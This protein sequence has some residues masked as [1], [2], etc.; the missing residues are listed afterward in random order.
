M[1][2]HSEILNRMKKRFS[3]FT[4][5]EIP[6]KSA[7]F[8]LKMNLP[9]LIGR[10]DAAAEAMNKIMQ[11]DLFSFKPAERIKIYHTEVTLLSSI[12]KDTYTILSMLTSPDTSSRER[13]MLKFWT[14][15]FDS[16]FCLETLAAADERLSQD[17]ETATDGF[18]SSSKL[19]K[20][21][22]F[23]GLNETEIRLSNRLRELFDAGAARLTRYREY[24]VKSFSKAYSERYFKAYNEYLE[25]YS[26]SVPHQ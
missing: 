6:S 11:L 15:L 21:P 23:S 1:D 12:K 17:P 3:I 14:L 18:I 25:L 5:Q 22:A 7:D 26:S 20:I 4:T 19:S 2:L 10:R 24:A 8:L 9:S 13:R 16:A